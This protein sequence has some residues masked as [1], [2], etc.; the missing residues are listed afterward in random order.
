MPALLPLF[1][2]LYW[3]G[4]RPALA[5]VS[6]TASVVSDYRLR[7][8]SLSDG[9]PVPQFTLAYDDPD[10]WYAGVFASNATLRAVGDTQQAMGYAGFAARIAPDLSWEAGA[11]KS[12]FRNGSAYDYNEVF[13]GL[14]ADR[15]SGRLSYAPN[16]FGKGTHSLYTEINGYHPLTDTLRLTGHL[17][18]LHAQTPG[19]FAPGTP[20]YRADIRLG[21]SLDIDAWKLQAALLAT[22]KKHPVYL[23][24]E[25][26]SQRALTLGLSYDF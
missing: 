8:V 4:A 12:V 6:A 5:Q 20:A 7:G 9:R 16:Y 2:A 26:G 22:Q 18:V 10:G 11:S 13:I 3:A 19:W 25:G 17:G 1:L 14:A 21:L 24:E 23:Y 15:I